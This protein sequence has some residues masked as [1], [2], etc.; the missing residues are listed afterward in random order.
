MWGVEL[1]LTA[2]LDWDEWSAPRSDCFNLGERTPGTHWE[3]GWPGLRACLDALVGGG[4]KISCL[5][6]ESNPNSLAVQVVAWSLYCLN[7]PGLF[8]K[9]VDLKI[10]GNIYNFLVP[11]LTDF[12]QTWNYRPALNLVELFRNLGVWFSSVSSVDGLWSNFACSRR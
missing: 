8:H 10:T 11:Y 9:I 2:V 5:D 6:R 3:E 4:A 1:F 7:Y 12:V